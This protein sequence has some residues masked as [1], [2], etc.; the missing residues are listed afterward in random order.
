MPSPSAS[1]SS[2]EQVPCALAPPRA[3][4]RVKD[5]LKLLGHLNAGYKPA[6]PADAPE[7]LAFPVTLGS[8]EQEGGSSSAASVATASALIQADAELAALVERVASV[9]LPQAKRRPQQQQQRRRGRAEAEA[10]ARAA[11][12]PPAA[13]TPPPA[14]SSGCRRVR[15]PAGVDV[16]SEEFACWFA[17][18]VA[19]VADAPEPV[20]LTHL[21]L[22]GEG[23]CAPDRDVLSAAQ[24]AALATAMPP[25][26][27]AAA[28]QQQRHTTVPLHVSRHQTIDLAGHRTPNTARNFAFVDVPLAEA[29]E[30]CADPT[31]HAPLL[32]PNE[33]LYLRSINASKT[34][35]HL[36]SLFPALAARLRL[37]AAYHPPERY[38]SSVLR[39][40]SAGARLW[41]HFDTR[42]NLLVQLAGAKTVALFPPRAD[43]GMSAAGSSARV[44]DVD[45]APLA[46]HRR[47][48]AEAMPL[49]RDAMLRPG[50]ALYLPAL[51]YHA[52]ASAPAPSGGLSAA[53]NVFWDAL[54]RCEYAPGD[55]Y[56]NR[57][58]CAAAA[59][60]DKARDAARLLRRLP[61]AHQELY[62]ARA[63]AAIARELRLP[64]SE[65]ALASS[66]A[67]VVRAPL[68]PLP[69]AGGAAPALALGTWQL[70]RAAARRV[71]EQAL[72]MGYRHVDTAPIYGNEAEVGEGIA[73]ALEAGV[74]ARHELF[75]TSKLWNSAHD[76]ADVES[77]VRRSV[78]SL[79]CGY[80]DLLLLHWPV[81][82][83]KRVPK[84]GCTADEAEERLVAT[85]RAME[86]LV[87]KGL[88]R[89]IGLSNFGP[90]K[91]A[92]IAAAA[93]APIA[94]VQL[95]AHPLWRNDEAL[96]AARDAG[97]TP[98]A[99]MVLGGVGA[100]AAT[101]AE[102]AAERAAADGSPCGSELDG[103]ALCVRWALA[104]G[105][106]AVVK[107]SSAAHL[108]A[109]LRAAAA[110]ASTPLPEPVAAA[111][112]ALEPQARRADGVAFLSAKGPWR[113]LEELW[114]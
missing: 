67:L 54:P 29:I 9:A 2:W 75:I 111:L 52:V 108:A 94:A 74:A 40:A 112:G 99:S 83:G 66:A 103:A 91:L 3:A 77:A 19:A 113:T 90:R 48:H 50:E 6:A 42:D 65:P 18:N 72:G 64:S 87:T 110:A 93:T 26:P 58:P 7:L 38:H 100:P 30:R 81:A 60:V 20:I 59:A 55:I 79:R 45:A 95:E 43:P 31:A 41:C 5:R 44:E 34:P 51:W 27:G 62:G 35:S 28:A 56:G 22:L 12:E 25:Q 97:A 69:A 8:C 63:V 89:A 70:P 104:R 61:R 57:D 68:L 96:R 13:S 11:W 15:A 80:L 76:P 71:V 37:P 24:L 47:F 53:V 46:E 101:A 36:P 39:L 73:A 114:A 107:A 4:K 109:N 17:A 85:W 21:D 23:P 98:C 1:G 102:R 82:S 86:A 16:T 10:A 32:A 78:G 105:C 106:V 33:A 84:G 88:V 14:S 92:R 49:R